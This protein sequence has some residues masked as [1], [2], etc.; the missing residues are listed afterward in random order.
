MRPIGLLAIGLVLATTF[1]VAAVAHALID[2]LSWEAAIVLGAVLGPTDPVAATAIAGR[3]GAPRRIV[4]IARG[5]EPHQRLDRAD[6]VQVRGRRRDGRG[7]SRCRGRR[8]VRARRRS[9][10]SR[11]ALS[12]PACVVEV[13]RRIDDAPTEAFLSLVTPYFAYL[14]A[15]ALGASGVVAAVTTGIYVGWHAPRLVTP[16][17][18]MQL[19]AMWDVLVFLLNSMLFVL[20]G[21]Q[22]PARA[23]RRC[24][25]RDPATLAA[26]RAWRSRS[27]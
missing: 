22:L 26:V 9:A 20:V 10:G 13:R 5:R 23:R 8:R 14:P 12:S 2:G 21:L 24:E 4:T 1:G 3:V 6:R 11:S 25:E 17:T 7:R 16:E 27:R 19:Y 18:R 15:D